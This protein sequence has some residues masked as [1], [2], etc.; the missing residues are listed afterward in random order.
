MNVVDS[1]SRSITSSKNSNDRNSRKRTISSNSNN[2]SIS[3]NSI[4]ELRP[5]PQ[6]QLR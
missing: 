5:Y 2:S 6:E 4:K 1:S 3:I